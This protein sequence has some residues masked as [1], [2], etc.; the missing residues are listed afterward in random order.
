MLLQWHITDEVGTAFVRVQGL[1]RIPLNSGIYS[2]M[3]GTDIHP[4]DFNDWATQELVDSLTSAATAY[5][6]ATNTIMRVNDASLMFGGKFDIGRRDT[7]TGQRVVIDCLDGAPDNCW[8]HVSRSS[9]GSWASG[10]NCT[11]KAIICTHVPPAPFTNDNE[12]A[13]RPL[14][15]LMIVLLGAAGPALEAQQASWYPP[16]NLVQPTVSVSV[17]LDSGSGDFL[18]S[19]SVTNGT[20]AQQRVNEFHIQSTGRVTGATGPANW[21]AL[22]N[23]IG[24]TT[25][26]A[27]GPSD[28]TWVAASD[29]DIPATLSEIAPG[30]SRAGFALKSQCAIAGFVTY[31]VRGYNHLVETPIDANGEF[32]PKPTWRADAVQ[33]SVLG[34][35][36]CSTVKDWG[37]KKAGV[38][39]F[40]GAVNFASGSTLLPGPVTLQFRFSRNGEQVTPS[41]FQ[42]V[43]N[44]T[45]VT[46]RFATNSA[47]DRVAVFAPGVAPLQRRNTIQV[48]VQGVSTTT[49]AVATDAD[50]YTFT[51]P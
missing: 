19:Y 41:T 8:G 13:M 10:L 43:L 1:T 38:D 4:E 6:A 39:G 18:Y 51:V 26:A 24:V 29:W 33:G 32:L 49:G 9:C 3:G 28:P 11:S 45:N 22:P 44:G 42:A 16:H 50:K 35:V 40:I 46:S 5:K 17:A 34:P 21:D 48:S 25:W 7:V 30:S 31:Y 36:D 2:R 20:G 15:L 14:A 37:V 27:S 12:T 23:P 47:G